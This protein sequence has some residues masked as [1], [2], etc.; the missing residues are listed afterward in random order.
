M[1][2]MRLHIYVAMAVFVVMIIVGSFL[3]LQ[4]NK[5]IFSAN[6]GFGIT[7]AAL[8]MMVGYGILSAMGG[9]FLY[10]GLKITKVTWQKVLFILVS[11]VILA[12]TVVLCARK[13]FFGIN[14]W[15]IRSLVWLGYLLSTPIMGACMFGGYL[16]A[17]KVNNPRLWILV[18]IG[19]A[20]VALALLLG[21][22]AVKSIFNR[23]RYRLVVNEHP[24]LFYNWWER[25][26]NSKD[27]ISQYGYG[28]E[29][30]KSFP[31]GH[32]SV[33]T[34]TIFGAT[35]IPFVYG[36]EIKH[37]VLY[38]YIGLAYALFVAFTRMWVGAHFLSDVGMGGLITTICAYACYEVVIH[39]P[40]LYE[41]PSLEEVKEA[42]E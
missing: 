29:E 7:V 28:A 23:P 41:N 3:D 4:I 39:N 37:Q 18:A 6:N 35:L 1:K 13:E 24:N 36:K 31:S 19:A 8:S 16:I 9:M 22:T 30:F 26:T 10:H 14:G 17:K 21:T 32:V 15:N 27:L 40:K 20:F 5:A 34:L 11:V 12:L 33:S 42:Q 25:C 38:F 2:K